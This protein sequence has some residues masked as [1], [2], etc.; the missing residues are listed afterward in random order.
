MAVRKRNDNDRISPLTH[1][2]GSEMSQD[3][4]VPPASSASSSVAALLAL[5]W[6]SLDPDPLETI[7]ARSQPYKLSH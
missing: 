4:D 2:Y 3:V 6:P 1:S 5:L 7:L